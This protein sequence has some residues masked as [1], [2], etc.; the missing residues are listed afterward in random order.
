MKNNYLDFDYQSSWTYCAATARVSFIYTSKSLSYS[1]EHTLLL[2]KLDTILH[3]LESP[4]DEG[5]MS[6]KQVCE[7]V[8]ISERTLNRK[9]K[10][11]M[12]RSKFTQGVEKYYAKSD[13]VL[14]YRRYH[15]RMPKTMP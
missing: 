4:V 9:V 7:Y 14:F 11:A 15:R 5:Y 2:H 3:L 10:E 8:G 6:T 13:V 1:A 12:I